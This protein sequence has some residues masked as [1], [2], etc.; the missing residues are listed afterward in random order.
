M[1]E[2]QMVMSPTGGKKKKTSE[3]RR[4][5]NGRPRGWGISMR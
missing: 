4:K 5:R 2:W 3:V 1:S